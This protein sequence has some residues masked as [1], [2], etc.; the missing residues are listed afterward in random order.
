M[1]EGAEGHR[2]LVFWGALLWLKYSEG[3]AQD[4]VGERNKKDSM[5]M[6]VAGIFC[7]KCGGNRSEAEAGMGA[8]E[9]HVQ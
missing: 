4:Q 8:G 2:C 6:D 1:C 5:K 7:S 3:D 9:I